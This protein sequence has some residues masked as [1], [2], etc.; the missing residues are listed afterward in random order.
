[1]NVAY[2]VLEGTPPQ[3]PAEQREPHTRLLKCALEIEEC[4]AY[5]TRRVDDEAPTT[6]RA[7][8]EFW[9]GSRSLSRVQVLL[10]NLKLRFDT[11]PDA[12]RALHRWS[13]SASRMSPDTRRTICHWHLQLADPLYREF[14]GRFLPER[15]ASPRP[16]VTRDVVVRFVAESDVEGRWTH[17]SHVQFASKLLSAAYSAGLLQRTRDPRPIVVPRVPDD[18]LEYFVQL[19]RQIDFVGSV[20]RNPYFASVGLDGASLEE[21]LRGLSNVTFERQADISY[22]TYRFPTVQAWAD[23]RF[24]RDAADAAA[25]D[26][27]S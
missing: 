19:L 23:A 13:T 17:A 14:T 6:E 16:E 8:E 18:A 3:R 25:Q 7:F 20:P 4:R 1:M 10:S 9:F 2:E 11:Y 15:L 21:R 22:V 5:W 27:P 26:A 24:P 12:L